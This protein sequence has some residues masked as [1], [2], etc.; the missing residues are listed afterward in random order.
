MKYFRI[1]FT[2]MSITL[3]IVGF[4]LLCLLCYGCRSY[5]IP[6]DPPVTPIMTHTI[7]ELKGYLGQDV[8]VERDECANYGVMSTVE[9]VGFEITFPNG[10]TRFYFY[11]TEPVVTP[12][13][14]RSPEITVNIPERAIK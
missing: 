1:F 11:S 14:Y 3:L 6:D 13:I 10:E 9:L 5:K 8:I 12:L 2:A 7:D 4:A